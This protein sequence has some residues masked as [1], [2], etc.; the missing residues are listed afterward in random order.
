M[1]QTTDA[2]ITQNGDEVQT[3]EIATSQAKSEN[4]VEVD[5]SIESD[6]KPTE[7]TADDTAKVETPGAAIEP[8]K[9]TETP[10]PKE[11]PV[12]ED[13]LPSKEPPVK[14][15][16]ETDFQFKIR[17]QMYLAQNA[18]RQAETPEEKEEISAYIKELREALPYSKGPKETPKENTIVNDNPD[19]A[20]KLAEVKKTLKELGLAEVT[21]VEAMITKV[22]KQQEI[23]KREAEHVKVIDDFYKTRPDILADKEKAKNLKDYITSNFKFTDETTPAQLA[24][25]LEMVSKTVF[26]KSTAKTVNSVKA[27]EVREKISI[28][29]G[30]TK[31]NTASD[32]KGVDPEIEIKLREMGWTDED[33]AGF[34]Y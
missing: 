2:L 7:S 26:P 5:Y 23:Q 24:F 29:G 13:N 18:K 10:K 32:K 16:T 6:P 17:T 27:E 34:K 1:T 28:S 12:V 11:A 8:A 21:D 20:A 9:G 31:G 33:L 30:N 3:H 22:L 14:L 15:D 19:E 25:W 4:M